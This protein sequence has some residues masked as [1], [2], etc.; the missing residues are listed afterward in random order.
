MQIQYIFSDKTGTLTQ[1]QMEFKK[2]SFGPLAKVSKQQKTGRPQQAAGFCS[3]G[4][5]TFGI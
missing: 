4:S 3:F 5:T 1:N 2:A